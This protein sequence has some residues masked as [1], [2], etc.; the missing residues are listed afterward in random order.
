[1]HLYGYKQAGV[2]NSMSPGVHHEVVVGM[3]TIIFLCYV[4]HYDMVL[5]YCNSHNVTY[6]ILNKFLSSTKLKRIQCSL[7]CSQHLPCVNVC[8]VYVSHTYIG[9][10]NVR[11][12]ANGNA[13]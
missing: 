12:I 8:T 10:L 9:V 6:I 13:Y 4:P 3:S 1:M 2:A 5:G 7:K 11:Y